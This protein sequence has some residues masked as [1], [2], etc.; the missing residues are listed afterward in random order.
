MIVLGPVEQIT[1]EG[2]YIRMRP[3][4]VIQRKKIPADTGFV[5]ELFCSIVNI[6]RKEKAER[7]AR[8]LKNAFPNDTEKI[9][10]Y[11][12]EDYLYTRNP[13]WEIVY[14]LLDQ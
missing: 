7:M 14:G 5:Y 11:I 13:Y 9:R 10:E 12:K 1:M 2:D 3:E 6:N 4:E 8:S